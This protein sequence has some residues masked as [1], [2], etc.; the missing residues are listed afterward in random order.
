MLTKKEIDMTLI[1]IKYLK[2]M[3]FRYQGN[4]LLYHITIII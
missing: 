4:T 3:G 2:I 1:I